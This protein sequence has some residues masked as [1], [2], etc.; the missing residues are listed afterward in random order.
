MLTDHGNVGLFF[1]ISAATFLC[2]GFFVKKL[3][4][5]TGSRNRVLICAF[6]LAV[7]AIGFILIGPAPMLAMNKTVWL[8]IAAV[9]LMGFGFAFSFIP[10]FALLFDIALPGTRTNSTAGGVERVTY[11]T[12][13]AVIWFVTFSIG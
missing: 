11:A 13:I 7:Q 4:D 8:S 2:F 6:G 9:V 12:S 3:V 10:T 1:L 5:T